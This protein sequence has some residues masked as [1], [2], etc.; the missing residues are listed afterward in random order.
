MDPV[1]VHGGR[2]RLVVE[3]LRRELVG[4]RRAGEPAPLAVHAHGASAI[5]LALV[6]W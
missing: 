3:A 1:M 5:P 4:L 2:E 6:L